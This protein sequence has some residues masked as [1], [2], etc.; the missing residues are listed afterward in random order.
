M[1]ERKKINLNGYVSIHL[2]SDDEIKS[3]HK[4]GN[5]RINITI[6]LIHLPLRKN[7]KLFLKIAPVWTKQVTSLFIQNMFN[8]KR[9]NIDRIV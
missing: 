7:K 4:T 6:R 2:L 1:T 8:L 9:G 5:K 3:I